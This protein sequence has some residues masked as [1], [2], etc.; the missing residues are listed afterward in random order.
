MLPGSDLF[1][2]VVI[3]KTVVIPSTHNMIM[4]AIACIAAIAC[5]NADD[6]VPD[7]H[8]TLPM[9]VEAGHLPNAIR[10]HERVISGGLPDGEAAFEEL[11]SLRVK[12]IISV[13]GAK[14][15]LALAAKYAM[16]YVHLPHGYN[17]ISDE[18]AVQ[19]AKAVCNFEGPI[20]IHCHHGKHRSPAAAAVACVAN[21]MLETGAAKEFL[22]FAGT[23]EHYV[24]LYQSVA[25]ARRLDSQLLHALDADF[26][27][28]AELPPLAE[29]MVEIDRNHDHLK[30]LSASGW[31]PLNDHPDL[32]PAHEA[33]MLLEHFTELLRL[34]SVVKESAE[35]RTMLKQSESDSR[36]LERLL[37]ERMTNTAI[38]SAEMDQSFKRLSDNCAACHKRYRDVPLSH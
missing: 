1:R 8:D 15:D 31:K 22:N 2:L 4:I 3:W 7:S 23:S 34:E 29:A 30:R 5:L 20:Y 14:P 38:G 9:R 10:I 18:H 24:G 33:L 12:T 13:D 11:K 26:P 28:T 35:F 32:D 36:A 16:R 19:L 37:R 27:E 17:G 21:G 25:K 6:T